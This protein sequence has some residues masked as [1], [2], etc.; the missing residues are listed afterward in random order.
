MCLYLLNKYIYLGN[1]HLRKR[2]KPGTIRAKGT[3][4]RTLVVQFRTGSGHGFLYRA[5]NFKFHKR[6]G[7]S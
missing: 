1:K 3:W 7:I 2:F 6:R 5:M 4:G